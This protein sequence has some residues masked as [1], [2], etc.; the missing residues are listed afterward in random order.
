MLQLQ[1]AAESRLLHYR[2]SGKAAIGNAKMVGTAA[3][4]P[5]LEPEQLSRVAAQDRD[6]LLVAERGRGEHVVDRMRLPGEGNVAADHD[7]ARADLR[8]EMAQSLGGEHEG[9]EIEL[10]E[11]L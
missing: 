10:I 11:V 8:R 1:L 9:I 2:R 5:Y 3:S 4:L 7:L 6:L